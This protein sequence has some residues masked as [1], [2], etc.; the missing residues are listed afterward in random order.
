MG[1]FDIQILGMS[2]SVDNLPT[3]LAEESTLLALGP[4][5]KNTS[6][7]LSQQQVAKK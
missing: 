3:P 2:D 4:L 1:A 7:L 5:Y 6:Q